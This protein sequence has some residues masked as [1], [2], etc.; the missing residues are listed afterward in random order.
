MGTPYSESIVQDVDLALKFLGIV[1][2]ENGA[3]VEGISDRNGSRRKVVYEVKVS[4]GEVHIP[5]IRGGSANSPIFF[6]V[7]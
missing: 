4:V 6:L 1:C 3:L 7:Q 2:R 5:K